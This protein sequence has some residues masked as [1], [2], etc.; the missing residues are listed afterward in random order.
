MFLDA[1]HL[2]DYF[3]YLYKHQGGI[4]GLLKF[5]TKEF[6]SGAYFQKWQKFITPLHAWEI[7][8]ISFLLFAVSLPFAN[9]FIAT[10][11][12]LT[13]HYIVDYF[14]NNVNK[15]AYFITYRAK[16]KFV[17]KAIAR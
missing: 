8:I 4:S 1:D 14:T 12:A 7:V 5:S 13:S 2:F 11:L 9:Y 10:S 17:K 16:N 15:K 3:L 6:L